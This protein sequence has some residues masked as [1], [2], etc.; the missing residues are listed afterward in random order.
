MVS[1]DP[2]EAVICGGE[3]ITHF[4][5]FQNKAVSYH[6][7]NTT[8]IEIIITLIASA[9]LK[10]ILKKSNF[11]SQDVELTISMDDFLMI[12]QQAKLC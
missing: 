3:E 10:K 12:A 11:S 6:A 7:G 9:H 5:A 4:M 1:S 2:E 8:W